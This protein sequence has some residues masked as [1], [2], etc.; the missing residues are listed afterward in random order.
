MNGKLNDEYKKYD[1]INIL[2]D[3]A[4]KGD[5]CAQCTLGLRYEK[6][7]G[8]E[9]DL[10]ESLHWYVQAKIQGDSWALEKCGSAQFT[11]INSY[12]FGLFFEAKEKYDKAI[13]WYTKA[14]TEESDYRIGNIYINK[15]NKLQEGIKWYCKSANKGYA[16]AQYELGLYFDRIAKN[17]KVAIK[18][19]KQAASQNYY[20]AQYCLGLLYKGKNLGKA[21]E[22]FYQASEHGYDMAQLEL[23]RMYRDS[24]QYKPAM[25]YYG[26]VIGQEGEAMRDAQVEL[27]EIIEK[28][29]L[30]VAK[31]TGLTPW[32]A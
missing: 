20:K 24:K 1:E 14:N 10:K 12:G 30:K 7:D 9:K 26:K 22:Y 4:S 15:L 32:E 19:Y 11:K 29:R 25:M 28:K 31:E 8:V 27:S 13:E 18:L 17:K 5:V 16:P 21:M 6:G 23:A 2:Y 3:K